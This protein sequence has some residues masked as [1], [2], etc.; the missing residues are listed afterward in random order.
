MSDAPETH[1]RL[2]RWAR[3]YDVLNRVL[4]L[5]RE[6]AFRQKVV[7]LAGVSPGDTVLDVGCGT[8]TLTMVAKERAGPNGEVHGIDAASEMI[9]EAQRKADRD[10]L[11]VRFQTALIE[12][13]PFPDESVDVV[14]SSLMLHHLPPDLKRRGVA[15]IAR[16]LRPG[17]RLFAVDFD[18]PWLGN[19]R[20]VEETMEAHGFL[21]IRRGKVLRWL[22]HFLTGTVEDVAA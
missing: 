3:S 14:L 10:G 19:L 21:S 5:G 2:I 20:I 6:R 12:D 22:I 1:G 16:V 18:P 15:E 13:L 9:R 8:G 4:F 11:D 17:G 7:D